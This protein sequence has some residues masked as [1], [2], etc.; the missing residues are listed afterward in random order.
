MVTNLPAKVK[1][2]WAEAVACRNIP[3]KIRL[4]KEFLAIC[5]KHKGTSKLLMNV[6][7]KIAALE[8]EL[9]RS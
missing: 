8:D 3:E 4:M 9:E 2:K 7:R 5:P 1:A 6:R